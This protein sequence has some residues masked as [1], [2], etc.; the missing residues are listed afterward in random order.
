MGPVSVGAEPGVH[1]PEEECDPD[2]R[3]VVKVFVGL[4]TALLLAALDQTGL[5][6]GRTGAAAGSALEGADPAASPESIAALPT[7]A[8]AAVRL[9]FSEAITDVLRL[10]VPLAL[11]AFA[12]TW[13]IQE[14]PLRTTTGHG[15]APGGAEDGEAV[16]VAG[17]MEP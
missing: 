14:R 11:L 3:H 1:A 10:A 13:L 16:P 7:A 15:R 17:V 2:R 4:C 12:L 5:G 6:T 9:V 8:R